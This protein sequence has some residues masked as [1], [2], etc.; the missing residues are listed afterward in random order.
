MDVMMFLAKEELRPNYL[1]KRF[2]AR[3]ELEQAI[4]W[5][6][7]QGRWGQI[8]EILRRE[9]PRTLDGACFE[10]L[11]RYFAL[12]RCFKLGGR[13][14]EAEAM[15]AILRG[16]EAEV[17]TGVP[18]RLATSRAGVPYQSYL[19]FRTNPLLRTLVGQR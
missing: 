2:G 13:M 6:L 5:L 10:L 16:I 11:E 7:R 19:R 14:M 4:H 1:P 8:V 17:A 12:S 15:A 3:A 9:S 18:T